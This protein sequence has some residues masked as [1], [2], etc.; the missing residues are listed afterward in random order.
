MTF[1]TRAAHAVEAVAR[2]AIDRGFAVAITVV[3]ASGVL[4]AFRRMH[5]SVTGPVEVSQKKARTA[6]LFGIDSIDLGPDAQP[7]G[8]IYSIEHT[9]GGLISFGGGVV[10]RDGDQI[11]GGLGV[12]GASVDADE[13]LARVGARVF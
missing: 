1:E 7:G 3:D 9:N 5:G 13:E 2:E 12:A 10:L 6:A 4:Q 8:P 11:I